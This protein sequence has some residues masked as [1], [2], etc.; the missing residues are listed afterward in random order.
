M[1]NKLITGILLF[2]LG[3]AF[4]TGIQIAFAQNDETESWT[5][6]H[7]PTGATGIGN[8][9]YYIL[10]YNDETGEVWVA[11]DGKEFRHIQNK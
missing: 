6:E 4:G 5:I 8:P 10:K 1:M 2:A 9:A 3:C 7:T 11:E